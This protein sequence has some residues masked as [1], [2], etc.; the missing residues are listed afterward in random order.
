M[1]G[2]LL[3]LSDARTAV[4]Q[5]VNGGSCDTTVIDSAIAEAEQR[6]WN[7]LRIDAPR[8]ALRRMRVRIQNRSLCLPWEVET[9]LHVDIDG[10]PAHVFGPSYEFLSAGPGDLDIRGLGTSYKD[11][12]DRGEY[13]TQFDVPV[14][15]TTSATDDSIC[16]ATADNGYTI[17]AFSKYAEDATQFITLQGLDK[18]SDEIYTTIDSAWTR[19][20]KIQ[21][22]RWAGGVEG[23]IVGQWAGLYATTNLFKQITRVVKPVTKGPVSLYAVNTT[24]NAMYL[25]SK[26]VPDT[27]IP[28]YRRYKITNQACTSDCAYVLLLARIR[29]R[30]AT[31]PDDTL[32]I[33]N[34]SAIKNMVMALDFEN[35]K[36]LA[37][38]AQYEAK[39]LQILLE[40][41]NIRT[42][43]AG[44]PVIIDI[45]K[46]LSAGMFNHPFAR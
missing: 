31:L 33:Q 17:V 9:V 26:M 8:L 25:L 1:T 22:N 27:T 42:D 41:K 4:K 40:E 32:S 43:S 7:K 35:K 15:L 44:M 34:L 30:K 12:A 23:E 3:V 21:I 14:L 29:F 28:M 19:G 10:T 46:Q 24:T 36:N 5:F 2:N 20:E 18:R 38:A 6:L 39:A 45:E 11:L 16:A 13:C 37:S